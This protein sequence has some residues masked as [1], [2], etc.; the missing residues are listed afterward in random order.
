MCTQDLLDIIEL[1]EDGGTIEDMADDDRWR[2]VGEY[3]KW[4]VMLVHEERSR[5][6]QA[7]KRDEAGSQMRDDNETRPIEDMMISC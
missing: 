2:G 4:L 3:G 6:R 5:R 7:V 1:L